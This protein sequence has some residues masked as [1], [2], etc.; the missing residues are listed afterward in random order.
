MLDG[1]KAKRSPVGVTLVCPSYVRGTGIAESDDLRPAEFLN[2]S[3]EGLD[4]SRISAIRNEWRRGFE[5]NGIPPADVAR[6]A[7]EG[8]RER[9]LYVF[10]NPGTAH[11]LKL[12]ASQMI[13]GKA[14]YSRE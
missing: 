5:E 1:S 13:A 11:E 8:I 14:V 10:P 9:K 4:P 7:L 6:A 2:E 12:R 3:E